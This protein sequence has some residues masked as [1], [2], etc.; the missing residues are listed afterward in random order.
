MSRDE[1]LRAALV[2]ADGV[3]AFL[4]VVVFVGTVLP[5]R[6]LDLPTGASSLGVVLLGVL[7][8]ACGTVLGTR[9]SLVERCRSRRKARLV[10]ALL[11]VGTLFV[12]SLAALPALGVDLSVRALILGVVG[13]ALVSVA[14]VVALGNGNRR[15]LLRRGLASVVDGVPAF[16]LWYASVWMLLPSLGQPAPTGATWTE[17][18]AV[19]VVLFFWSAVVRVPFE[20]YDG[21]SVGKRLAGVR[22]VDEEGDTPGLRAVLVRNALR[23]VDSLPFGYVVGLSYAARSDGMRRIGDAFAETRVVRNERSS[24]RDDTS[25]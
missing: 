20:A 22:V 6:P 12:A 16:A 8:F 3:L 24:E 11:V 15:L 7:G 17:I 10:D 2:L 9:P 18:I 5:S 25:S 4:L 21:R 23:P 13:V 1:R 14:P 19:V